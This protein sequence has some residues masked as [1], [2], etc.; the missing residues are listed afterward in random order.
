MKGRLTT[1]IA[2]CSKN[3]MV[4]KEKKITMDDKREL[5]G[6]FRQNMLF[7]GISRTSI[8]KKLL[9]WACM[10]NEMMLE[11]VQGFVEMH[12]LISS[13]S[14]QPYSRDDKGSITC[15]KPQPSDS[16]SQPKF[17]LL[18]RKAG[19]WVSHTCLVF[20]ECPS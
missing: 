13:R 11:S 5:W 16:N 7:F 2:N 12:P 17:E 3:M 4:V 14:V 6:Q 19:L 10:H 15:C 9:R 20:Y 8:R 1:V 18:S